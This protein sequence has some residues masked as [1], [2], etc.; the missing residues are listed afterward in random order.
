MALTLLLRVRLL[1]PALLAALAAL[2]PAY[3]G[4]TTAVVV[5]IAGRPEQIQRVP[6]VEIV[7]VATSI[8]TA[9]LLRPRFWEWERLGGGHVRV[10]AA[11][12]ALVG[13]LLPLLPA[14]VA[15]LRLPPE[16][17]P[18]LVLP[19]VLLFSALTFAATALVGPVGGGLLSLLAV[20]G[21]AVVLNLQPGAA[22]VLPVSYAGGQGHRLPGMPYWWLGPLLMTAAA[23]AVHATTAGATTWSRR[24]LR[25]EE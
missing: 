25:N 6:Y 4:A 10:H 16:T 22:R 14:A 24:L 5:D 13:L 11:A 2:V 9:W 20:A 7:A 21:G 18:W 3:A 23:L 19:P 12:V 8:A 17:R 1:L 15:V